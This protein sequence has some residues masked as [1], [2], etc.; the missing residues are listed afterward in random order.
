MKPGGRIVLPLSRAAVLAVALGGGWALAAPAPPAS[1]PGAASRGPGAAADPAAEARALA[2]AG[3]SQLA[4]K[5]ID[6]SQPDFSANP[7]TWSGWERARLHILS[8]AGDYRR[9]F[10][11]IAALPATAGTPLR[12]YALG[13]GARAALA[14]NDASRAR[15]YLRRLIWRTPAPASAALSGYRRLVV[16]SYIV[17]GELD[18]AARALALLHR[19]GTGA[20]WR[21]REI[22]A[23]VALERGDPHKAVR[24]LSGLKKPRLRPLML[25]AELETGIHSPARVEELAS[26]LASGAEHHK[27]KRLAGRFQRVRA[28]AG[29]RARKPEIRLAALL[30]ALRLDPVD[31]GPFRV[32]P[33]TVWHA[34]VTTGLAL[35]NARQLLLGDA[36]P[37][38]AAADKARKR[39][40]PMHALALLAAAGS[41]SPG[42]AARAKAL[43]AFGHDLARRPHGAR[44]ALTFFSDHSLF[45]DPSN[46]PGPLRYALVQPAVSAGHVQF[47][48]TLLQDLDKP[49][50]GV[51][52]G[53]WQLERARLFLLGG[54]TKR[55]VALLG[56]LARGQ[57]DVAP[58]KLLPVVLDLETLGQN[59]AALG[60][61]EAMLEG[62]PPPKIARHI[63]YWIGKAYGGL[64]ASLNAARAYLE[65]ATFNSP[66][67]MDQWART[68]RF[69]AASSLTDAGLYGDARRIYEGLLNATSDPTQQALLKERLAAVRTLA[70][71]AA[72]KGGGGGD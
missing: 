4:L 66:Y 27:D 31:S 9:L 53:A 29:A 17:G 18:D 7:D 54:E 3:A 11:R 30:E 62:H 2:S 61:L 59:K 51:D 22:A 64:G 67:A 56:R 23:E 25:L 49:P 36:G 63:L 37:W 19:G 21:T 69:S 55:G 72:E 45:A 28:S 6:V 40:R 57:P 16:R 60:V 13:V 46:L 65:S 10:G 39:H 43:A 33:G 12:V 32:T 5:L 47:A 20:G 44:A 15:R 42:A 58:G 70:N 24:L 34:F 14:D 26:K 68:A 48:S 8:G 52:A 1:A 71:R 38:L 50:P 41:R 35:G